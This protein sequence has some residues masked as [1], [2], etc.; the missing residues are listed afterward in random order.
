[1]TSLTDQLREAQRELTRR[2]VLYP[3]WC[4]EERLTPT[5]AR[6]RLN[7]QRAIVATLERLAAMKAWAQGQRG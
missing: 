7:A 5:M 6:Q 3:R 2:S 4:C 1:M